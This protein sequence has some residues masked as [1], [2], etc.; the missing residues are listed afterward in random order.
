MNCDYDKLSKT[1]KQKFH[2]F[3]NEACRKRLKKQGNN[4]NRFER[5]EDE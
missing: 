3:R 1:E 5:K 2:N 4:I